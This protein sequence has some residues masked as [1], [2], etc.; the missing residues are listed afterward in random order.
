LV[1]IGRFLNVN[2]M[3][4]GQYEVSVASEVQ[5][6]RLKSNSAVQNAWPTGPAGIDRRRLP[7]DKVLPTEVR[8]PVGAQKA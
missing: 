7:R 6:R 3:F 5:A 8:P 2:D 4:V 1:S